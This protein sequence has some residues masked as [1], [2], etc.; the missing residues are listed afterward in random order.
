M[1]H[2]W[3]ILTLLSFDKLHYKFCFL[4][5]CET[6]VQ[7]WTTLT[8]ACHKTGLSV[9]VRITLYGLEVGN[10]LSPRTTG[11]VGKLKVWGNGTIIEKCTGS[12]Q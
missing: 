10:S 5:V 11:L 4:S 6:A 7:H 8:M 3:Y 1:K 9:N 12:S 2:S